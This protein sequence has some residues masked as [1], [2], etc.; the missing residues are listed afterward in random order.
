MVTPWH[1]KEYVHNQDNQCFAVSLMNLMIFQD[2]NETKKRLFQRAKRC[3]LIS[4]DNTIN[5]YLTTRAVHE[6]TDGLYTP[7]LYTSKDMDFETAFIKT[8][9][10]Q[11]KPELIR[12]FVKIAEEEVDAGRIKSAYELEDPKY[13]YIEFCDPD[14]GGIR[15]CMLR[16]NP[17]YYIDNG[18]VRD[19]VHVYRQFPDEAVF[20]ILELK[21]KRNGKSS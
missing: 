9:Y 16:I 7:T 5:L 12:S 2:D 17:F 21:K 10:G 13:P 14:D 20:G 19:F 1:E 11:H 6:L 8:Y 15:H 3:K 18:N 4:T